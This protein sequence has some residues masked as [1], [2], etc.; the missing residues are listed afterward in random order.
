MES[1]YWIECPEALDSGQ[2]TSGQICTIL[3][4]YEDVVAASKFSFSLPY[5]GRRWHHRQNHSSIEK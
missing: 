5:L 1:S 4:T 3:E 2:D